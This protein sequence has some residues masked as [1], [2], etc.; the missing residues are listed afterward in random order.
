MKKNGDFRFRIVELN[1]MEEEFFKKRGRLLNKDANLNQWSLSFSLYIYKRQAGWNTRFS[2][3]AHFLIVFLMQT[4]WES[5]Q[6]VRVHTGN[7]AEK[8][9]RVSLQTMQPSA[10]VHEWAK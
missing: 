7:R 5:M 2:N 8:W 10:G 4:H 9:K 6:V 1:N 3:I